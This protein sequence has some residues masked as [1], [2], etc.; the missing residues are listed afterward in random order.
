MELIILWILFCILIGFM[1]N[2][3]G[4]S[5]YGFFLLSLFLSPLIGL[6]IVLIIMPDRHNIPNVPAPPKLSGLQPQTLKKCPLCAEYIKEEAIVCRFCG[7]DVP[8]TIIP[9]PSEDDKKIEEH[10][11]RLREAYLNGF[12]YKFRVR[13][14]TLKKG[15]DSYFIKNHKKLAKFRQARKR[16]LYKELLMYQNREY[17]KRTTAAFMNR[18]TGIG[19]RYYP[20]LTTSNYIILLTLFLFTLSIYGISRIDEDPV[21][22]PASQEDNTPAIIDPTNAI[23]VKDN[24]FL[25]DN[26][27][28]PA[29][30][31]KI[32]KDTRVIV[33]GYADAPYNTYSIETNDLYGSIEESCIQKEGD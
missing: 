8:K 32:P 24:C 9:I 27:V 26:S 29:K 5:G 14:Q 7:R 21:I 4:R 17:G 18:G 2:L 15:K 6:I 23:I 12:W 1:A 33:H 28:T 25:I 3:K 16:V 13:R 22:V 10:V 11:K 19:D 30:H 31:T 20:P